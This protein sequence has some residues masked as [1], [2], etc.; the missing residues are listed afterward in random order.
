MP[1]RRRWAGAGLTAA[2]WLAWPVTAG[3]Q[4]NG[5]PSALRLADGAFT[6]KPTGLLQIDLGTTFNHSRSGG[7]GGG[8]NVRRGRLG[9]EGGF[10]DDVSY[11]LTWDFGGTPGDQNRLYEAS[12][13]WKV[14]DPVTLIA[15]VFEPSF[16][17]QRGQSAADLLFL[18][19]AAITSA[20]SSL[21]ANSG[22]VGLEARANGD[23]WFTSG[24]LTGGQTGPG[25]D[26]SQ[27]GAVARLT[28]LPLKAAALTVH[29]GVSGAWSFRPPR[30]SGG[31]RSVTLSA[32]T[33]LALDRRDTLLDTGAIPAGS[34]YTGG[35]ELGLGW[36]RLA[37]QGEWYG[38]AVNQAGGG[39]RH[40]SGWYAQASWTFLGQPRAY[41]PRNATWGAPMPEEG[42]FDPRAGRWGALEAGVRFSMLD[43]NDADIRGG[44]Q[45]IWSTGLGWWPSAH[46]G[47]F[48]QYQY[49]E[50]TGAASGNQR[51][52]ALAVRTQVTF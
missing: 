39:T 2:I 41:Q 7:P 4:E 46:F 13:S 5:W 44:Q 51:F 17:L 47:V 48:T 36:R 8:A 34:A 20:A 28:G 26:S 30:G 19:R 35:V 32:D 38:I 1:G 21:A 10:A 50:I 14:L 49:V 31:S 42:G 25:T 27:R 11:N 29:L 52:Q 16:S 33:E 3:A 43:L 37:L 40:F 9:V 6:A 45:R 23:R 22:Q 24:T 15:G 12:L 18:E